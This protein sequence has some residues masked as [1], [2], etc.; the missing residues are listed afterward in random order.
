MEKR[1]SGNKKP[2]LVLAGA[3][4][5]SLRAQVYNFGED[6]E[7][8]NSQGRAVSYLGSTI[9]NEVK[10]LRG[11]YTNLEG[12]QIDY[13]EVVLDTCLVTVSQNKT[14]IKTPIQGR[15]GTVKEYISDGDYA[16]TIRGL[17]ASESSKAYPEKEV[18]NLVDACK[19]QQEV[20]IVSTFLN[21]VFGINDLV[22]ESYSLPQT[23]GY[24]NMQLFE[25]NGVS[26]EPAELI[27]RQA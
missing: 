21:K 24:E 6:E 10:I 13:S 9:F 19:V 18:K 14:I 5:Q 17:I 26:E 4:L 2:G 1:V 12:E 7:D 8:P 3:G 20:E 27:I 23:E 11:S 25:L 15:N 22:I 16:V